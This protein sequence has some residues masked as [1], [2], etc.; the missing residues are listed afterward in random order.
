MPHNSQA[1]AEAHRKKRRWL[2]AVSCLA[3]LVVFG[4]VGALVLPARTLE[5]ATYCGMEEHTHEEN[6]YTSVLTCG[7]TEESGHVHQDSCYATELTCP[8]AEHTHTDACYVNPEAQDVE[9]QAA[10]TGTETGAEPGTGSADS[11]AGNTENTVSGNGGTVVPE[12][13]TG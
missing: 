3:A 12:E 1:F 4:T 9:T 11:E 13:Q 2:A 8:L 7:L 10:Q 6:C 5:G